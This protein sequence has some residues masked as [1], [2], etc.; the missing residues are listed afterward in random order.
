M[1]TN[2][3]GLYFVFMFYQ[4]MYEYVNISTPPISHYFSTTTTTTT[5]R[6]PEHLYLD[7]SY[8][9]IFIYIMH[10]SKEPSIRI[11]HGEKKRRIYLYLSIHF[12]PV[13]GLGARGEFVDT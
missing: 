2:L 4:C 10:P 13:M 6:M 1:A 12:P 5:Q 9:W 7:S 8:T 3:G 11:T